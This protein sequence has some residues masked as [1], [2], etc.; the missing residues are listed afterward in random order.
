VLGWVNMRVVI[1]MLMPDLLQIGP[2]VG[3]T[4][5]EPVLKDPLTGL[6]A[7]MDFIGVSYSPQSNRA[8][9]FSRSE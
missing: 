8:N 9:T 3:D 6:G 5:H 4:V 1:E 7:L 2:V